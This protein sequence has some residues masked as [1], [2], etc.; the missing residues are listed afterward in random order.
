MNQPRPSGATGPLGALVRLGAFLVVALVAGAVAAAMVLPLA[1]GAGLVTR[2]AVESFESLPDQLDAPDLPER[3]VILARDGSILATIYYQNRVEV[4]IT[5]VSPMMREAVVAIEDARFLDHP[6]IDLRGTVRAIVSNA[7]GGASQQGGSTL[8]QQYVKN[9]L[10]DSA[11]TEEDLAAARARTP[12][13]KL[14]EIRYALALER[15]YTKEQILEK[16]LNIV[17]FGAGAYGVEAASRRYFSKPASDLDL[18]Q[19]AT[20]EIGRAHV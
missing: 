15:R 8:T 18:T 1:A 11:T 7:S 14:R 10:I 17:Y 2:A 19:A 20:L 9:V 16:Y 6:G 4:P 13:R 12:A 3:S 5:S